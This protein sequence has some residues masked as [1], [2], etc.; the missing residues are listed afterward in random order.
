MLFPSLGG[1]AYLYALGAP[2]RLV[3]VNAGALALALAWVVWGWLPEGRRSR[4]GFAATALLL[5]FLPPLL[6]HDVDGVSRWLPLGRALFLH[7]GALLLPLIIV[8][9]AREP[10]IGPWLLAIATVALALQPDAGVLTG[11]AAASAA[12]AALHRSLTIALVAGGS[13]TLALATFGA[14]DLAPQ[15]YTEG[16]LDHVAEHSLAG[17]AALGLVLFGTPLWYLVIRA[18]APQEEGYALAALIIAFGIIAFIAPFPYPLIG[19]G[20]APILGFGLALGASRHVTPV[21][22]KSG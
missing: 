1:L 17:A 15:L 21:G 10:R 14:G 3:A 12:L 5:L 20:A 11:L 6:Q 22:T 18:A 9:A 19:Y 13:L 16:V 4:I 2:A 8:I 7:S